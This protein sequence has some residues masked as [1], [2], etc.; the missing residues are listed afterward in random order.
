MHKAV[1]GDTLRREMSWSD[2]LAE[3]KDC[4]AT[5]SD[6]V[7]ASFAYGLSDR[8]R[9]LCGQHG[10]AAT[11]IG[12]IPLP[13]EGQPLVIPIRILWRIPLDEHCRRRRDGS[14]KSKMR[15]R[16]TSKTPGR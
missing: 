5:S 3:S 9:D 11:R 15:A 12:Q 10:E 1:K 2:V 6:C 7:S 13:R 4:V 16:S 14:R 8:Y